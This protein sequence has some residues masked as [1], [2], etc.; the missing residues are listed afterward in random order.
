MTAIA[1]PTPVSDS[2]KSSIIPNSPWRVVK[3]TV[4]WLDFDDLAEVDGFLDATIDFSAQV[5][6]VDYGPHMF[7]I[8]I[9]ADIIHGP[10]AVP[11]RIGRLTVY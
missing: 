3:I 10:D 4:D 11:D 6:R 7:D 5:H 1:H 2:S 9:N 8:T